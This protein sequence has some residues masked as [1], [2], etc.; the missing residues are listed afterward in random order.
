MGAFQKR[1]ASLRNDKGKTDLTVAIS[2][3]G[4]VRVERGEELRG[5]GVTVREH[6]VKL[7]GDER[8]GQAAK[9]AKG[10]GVEDLVMKEGAQSVGA[11]LGTQAVAVTPGGEGASFELDVAEVDRSTQTQ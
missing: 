4:L 6:V 3:L 8:F 9:K 10:R 1:I 5:L 11:G 2:G 7:Q